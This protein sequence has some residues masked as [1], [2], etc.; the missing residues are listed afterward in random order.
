VS[1]LAFVIILEKK[2]LTSNS[3]KSSLVMTIFR[4]LEISG[5]SIVIDGLD[6]STLP[7]EEIRSR[8]IGVPQDSFILAGTVRLNVDPK[9]IA[10]DS[11]IIEALKSVQLWDNVKEKGGLDIDIEKVHLSHGQRQLFCLAR[12]MLRPSTVL[13]LDE[14]T[15]SV[16]AKTD[17]LMQ[18]IIREKFSAHTIIAVAHKLDSILDYDKVALLHEGRIVEFDSPYELLSQPKSAFYKLYFSSHQDEEEDFDDN[19]TLAGQ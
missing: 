15:S 17:E 14:A 10:R 5:G 1:V 18:R 8:L 19:I 2:S 13:V 6:I 11:E 12:A 16:D 9:K 4:M 7:R 3:G